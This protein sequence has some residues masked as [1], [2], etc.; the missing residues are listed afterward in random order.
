MTI[1]SNT[2]NIPATYISNSTTPVQLT[3][4]QV[5]QIYVTATGVL[6]SQVAATPGTFPANTFAICEVTTDSCCLI[7]NIFDW[8]PSYI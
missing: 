1:N 4:G 5:N 7:R 3:A 6:T 2:I 8:R